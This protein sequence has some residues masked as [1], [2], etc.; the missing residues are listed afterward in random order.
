MI[1]EHIIES[2]KKEESYK[3]INDDVVR[4]IIDLVNN[5]VDND[6]TLKEKLKNKL[7]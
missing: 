6:Q 2:L 7:A 1:P 3:D 5:E 4:E